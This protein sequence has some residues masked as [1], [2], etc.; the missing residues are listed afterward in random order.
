M[1]TASL[2]MTLP[3]RYYTDP[4]L[5]RRERERFFFGRWICAGRE[6]R[7]ARPGDYFLCDVA[8]ESVI[9][10][11]DASGEVRAFYNVCRHRGARLC[12]APEGAFASRITCPYHAWSYALDGS[13]AV[14]PN[15]DQPG[16]SRDDY[17]LHSV[18]AEVWQGHVLLHLGS[19]AEPAAVELAPLARKFAAWQMADLRL[20][21]RIVYDVKANWKL[22]IL[23]YNECLHCPVVHPALN[24]LTDYLGADNEP[25]NSTYIGGV[26][27]LRPSADTMSFQGSLHGRRVLPGL[28][29][30]QRKWAAYYAIYPNFL[31]ALH[32]DYM[33][34]HLLWP[35]AV[36]RTEIVCEWHFPPEE[37]ARPDFHAEDAVGF[38]DQVNRE[39]WRVAEL[40]QLG[41]SSRAYTPGPYS[42]REEL[43]QAFDREVLAAEG[44]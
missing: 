20:Y 14:A 19:P 32:P 16:F 23:N 17:P 5:F 7:V 37:M 39:D 38:W 4:E 33:V 15:M 2:P 31:L 28:S 9:V 21:K 13:L 11:R 1:K 42:K 44:E 27:T 30:V 18:R 22:I 24:P 34:T 25:P 43:L 40:S 10:T 26:M 3:A 6:E 41:I 12:T 29:A 8:G 35:K 36:D